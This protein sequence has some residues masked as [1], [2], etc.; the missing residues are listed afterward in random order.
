MKKIIYSTLLAVSFCACTKETIHYQ[1]PVPGE[2]GSETNATLAIA[3]RNTLFT[4]KDDVN[5]SIAFKSLGGKVVLDVNTN[6]EWTYEIGGDN[7]VKAEKDDESSLLTLSC[8]QNKI[9]RTL[10][11]TVTIKA[12]DKTATVSATQNAYGTVEIVASENNFHLAAAGELT[13][14]FEVTSTDPDWTFETSGCEWMLVTKDG[15]TINL[16]AYQNEEYTDREV[17]FTLKAGSGDNLVTETIDVLQDRAAL[18]EPSASTVPITPFSSEAKEVEVSAN[19]DWEYSISGNESGWLTIERTEKGLKFIP[20]ANPGSDSRTVKIKITTGDGKENIDTKEITVSQPGIDTQAF[21]IGLNVTKS[22]YK[23]AIPVSGV[24]AGATVDWGDGTTE[25]VESDYPAHTYTDPGYYIASFKG[26]ATGIDAYSKLTTD[27]RIQISEVFCWG[28]LEVETMNRAFY[29]CDSLK[30]IP[31]D[32][33]GSF[34]KV[35]TF[36]ETFSNCQHLEAIPSGLLSKAVECESINSMLIYCHSIKEIPA[37]L[38]YNCPKLTDV[39]SAFD[40]CKSVTHVD[41][42]I[43]SK[44]PE[45]TD[46]SSTFSRMHKLQSVSEDLFANN[47]KI[48]TFNAV[49]NAD[50]SLTS[51]PAGIFRNQPDCESFRM[52]FT[53]SGLVEIPAGLFANNTKCETFEQTFSKTKIKRIP[54]DVFKG[55]S[56]VNSFMSCFNGCSELE[57]IPADLFKNSG[58][59]G[60]VYGKRGAGMNMIFQGCSSLKEIPAGIL[61]GFTRITALNSIFNGCSSLESIPSDLFKDAAAVTSFSS[62]FSGCTA[63]KSIPAGVF[64]GLAKVTSFAGVFQGCTG[65][66]EIGDNLFEG[67]DANKNI[68]NLFKGCV[69]LAKVAENAFK[70][71]GKVTNISGLFY[72]CTNLKAIPEGALAELA[73]VTNAKEVFSNSGIQSVPAGLFEAIVNTTSFEGAFGQRP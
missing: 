44:N 19:F 70:G 45:I 72:G 71:C 11:A 18:I 56:S 73:G 35:K 37:D 62:A 22:P 6:K 16:S 7:F 57:S 58:A 61:D 30:R 46:C 32:V 43:F 55:C 54:A 69:S 60:V 53:G 39:G 59:Q 13:A 24:T 51:V 42:N 31:T 4:A 36:E 50:S 66:T 5:A 15:N 38:L 64:K 48:T 65:I 68:S 29:N 21:I 1:N 27:Q 52:A 26:K 23:S 25:T 49:F 41:K 10:T 17:K 34:T 9:D 33:I 14:S 40:M 12:G 8:D 47:P 20:T 2:N 3:S 67:C 28:N 63:L